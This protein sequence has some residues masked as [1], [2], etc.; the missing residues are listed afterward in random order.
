MG[1][2]ETQLAKENEKSVV[3]LVLVMGQVDKEK[4]IFQGTQVYG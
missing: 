1:S 2:S 3:L 4:P